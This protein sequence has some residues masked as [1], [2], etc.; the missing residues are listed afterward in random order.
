[1][2]TGLAVGAG[3]AGGIGG[4]V[5]SQGVG[6]ATGLQDRFSFKA[7]ALAGIAGGI[8]GGLGKVIGGSGFVAGAARGAAGS[9]L[10]QGIATVTG[11]QSR[12]SFAGVAAAAIGGG[13]GA[14]LGGSLA[15]LTGAGANL[16]LGNIASHLGVSAASSLAGAA[17]RTALSGTGFGDSVLA[18]LP[19]VIGSTI[20][21]VI[22]GAV[23]D[24][25][26]ASSNDRTGGFYDLDGVQLAGELPAGLAIDRGKR[27]PE[28][29][30]ALARKALNQ[31][32]NDEQK[33]YIEETLRQL[34][35]ARQ[36]DPAL[37]TVSPAADESLRF[38]SLADTPAANIYVR[39]DNPYV[40]P[41]V[42]RLLNLPANGW[43]TNPGG[44]SDGLR[45]YSVPTESRQVFALAN[46]TN[47]TGTRT[48]F[49]SYQAQQGY[50]Y[51][52][53]RRTEGTFAGIGY[54]A[55]TA[56]GATPGTVNL[57]SGLGGSIDG[58]AIGSKLGP[59]RV[60]STRV[61]N[62][63]SVVTGG[64]ITK[65]VP[66]PYGKLGGPRSPCAGSG[67][68]FEYSKQ[69]ASNPRQNFK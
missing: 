44:Y 58:F 20:G 31:A 36:Y 63:D 22:A 61:T 19:D 49:N 12:F 8:G 23:G 68:Y 5:A 52:L 40:G 69:K 33:A 18:G 27:T 38:S 55:L 2:G 46:G 6:I 53:A 32:Q 10:T 67:N 13:L 15:P 39:A 66:N 28:E 7:V 37:Q 45:N 48:Q 57:A 17:T 50:A 60:Y 30:I 26:R 51:D 43:L 65:F 56:L 4:S 42:S 16:S 3:A 29:D 59:G 47:F 54:S 41:N 34:L 62:Y 25:G 11:L 9:A 1:M 24:G 14:E 64:L 35:A 21:N